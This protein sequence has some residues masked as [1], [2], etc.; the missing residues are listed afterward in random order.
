MTDDTA[1]LNQGFENLHNPNPKNED[2]GPVSPEQKVVKVAPN[3]V[4]N[5]QIVRKIEYYFSC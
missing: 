5:M 2:V 1:K 3:P 4:L